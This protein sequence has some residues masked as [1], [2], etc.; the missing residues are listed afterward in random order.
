MAVA[1]FTI[2]GQAKAIP[3]HK[4]AGTGIKDYA[5]RLPPA[6]LVEES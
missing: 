5:N 4:S 2:A 3:V 6:S 1:M